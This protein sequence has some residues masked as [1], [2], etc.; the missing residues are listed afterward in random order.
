MLK[1]LVIEIRYPG[2]GDHLFHSHI[3]RIAKETG[4]YD[5]VYISSKSLF[6]HP[7]TKYIV[8]DLNPFVDGFIDESVITCDAQKLIN[9][10]NDIHFMD[11]MPKKL[12]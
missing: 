4:K 10:P 2:L 9:D 3:P 8:W 5:A 1:T 6:R 11:E 7:D 12:F